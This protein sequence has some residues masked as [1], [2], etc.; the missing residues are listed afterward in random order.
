MS[1]AAIGIDQLAQWDRVV[2]IG[3]QSGR[4]VGKLRRHSELANDFIRNEV[5]PELGTALY[6]G[7]LGYGHDIDLFVAALRNCATT[8]TA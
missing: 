6:F 1:S 8:G 7:N 5:E 4:A 2:K 3:E